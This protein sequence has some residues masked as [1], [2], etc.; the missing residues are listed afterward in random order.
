MPEVP[1][2]ASSAER[3]Q[4]LLL[5]GRVV[6]LPCLHE[7]PQTGTDLDAHLPIPRNQLKSALR[8]ESCA[9]FLAPKTLV[10]DLVPILRNPQASSTPHHYW[11]LQAMPAAPQRD[12]D[13]LLMPS[14][15]PLAELS[16]EPS[17]SVASHL[18]ETESQQQPWP[19][20]LVQHS[21][22]LM[23]EELAVAPTMPNQRDSP[24]PSKVP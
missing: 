8:A 13:S 9:E 1:A 7:T 3:H 11:T 15:V 14:E 5:L 2:R 17:E 4:L 10:T 23:A 16:L 22:L 6:P 21:L 24:D 18:E 20:P 19:S 12:A